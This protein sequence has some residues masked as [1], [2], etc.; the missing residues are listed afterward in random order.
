MTAVRDF[1]PSLDFLLSTPP[2]ANPLSLSLLSVPLQ[3]HT[4]SPRTRSALLFRSI[5]RKP[6]SGSLPGMPTRRPRSRQ[7]SESGFERAL[8]P[9]SPTPRS[10]PTLCTPS[11]ITL[12]LPPRP[13]AASSWAARRGRGWSSRVAEAA[14]LF[15]LC[16]CVFCCCEGRRRTRRRKLSW[17]P[18]RTSE[19]HDYYYFFDSFY[20]TMKDFK[21]EKRNIHK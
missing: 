13:R 9:G 7:P 11:P 15:L 14:C 2:W 6:R 8:F 18:S 20:L 16:F 17:Q 21:R 4:R 5:L 19:A 10:P 12:P 3:S 1:P